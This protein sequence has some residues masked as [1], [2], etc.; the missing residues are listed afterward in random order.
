VA[1]S[2]LGTIEPGFDWRY[3]PVDVLGDVAIRATQSYTAG[4]V[5]WYNR[6]YLGELY[7]TPEGEF[8]FLRR[9]Y[10]STTPTIFEL[11]IPPRLMEA[12]YGLRALACKHGM[13]GVSIVANWRL[14]LEQWSPPTNPETEI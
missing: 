2:S 14:E 13:N 7:G 3:F 5:T 10:I 1:W 6:L 8:R 12:G 11:A 4:E 9:L